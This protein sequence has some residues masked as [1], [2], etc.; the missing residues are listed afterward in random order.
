MS[1][2]LDLEI[3]KEIDKISKDI[4]TILDKVETV[5]P[6]GQKQQNNPVPNEHNLQE[7][8]PKS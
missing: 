5:Y 2:P 4:K 7:E 1:E 6:K 8:E 3:A